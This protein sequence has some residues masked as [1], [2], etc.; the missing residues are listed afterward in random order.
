MDYFLTEEEESKIPVLDVYYD[1]W[2]NGGRNLSARELFK[3]E[4]Y[5]IIQRAS[6]FAESKS[7]ESYVPKGPTIWETYFRDATKFATLCRQFSKLC[8]KSAQTNGC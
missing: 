5:G 3:G 6:E 7:D 2:E 1:R 4:E 8:L